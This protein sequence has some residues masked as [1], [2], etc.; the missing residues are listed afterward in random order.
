MAYVFDHRRV[1]RSGLA[2]ELVV[3]PECLQEFD[4]DAL[5]RQFAR[6][7]YA[8]SFKVQNTTFVLVTMHVTYGDDSVDRIRELRGIAR[9]MS[10]WAKRSNKW[11]HNLI[12]LGDFN[13]DR[14]GDQLWE[15]FVSTGLTVP[16]DL[17]QVRRRLFS[18][19][20]NLTARNSMIRLP[21]LRR[22]VDC[23]GCRF[24]TYDVVPLTSFRTYIE[25]KNLL[26]ANSLF[27]FGFLTITHFGPSFLSFR[28]S[29][30]PRKHYYPQLR[31]A[32]N[33]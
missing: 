3:S 21:D 12:V 28:I 22:Q 26:D 6:T 32:N 33:G 11:H 7:P 27:I 5:K 20:V 8:V 9:W 15:A 23:R 24:H 25:T 1:Q 17:H 14:R 29:K 10:D 4:E 16:E 18:K 31:S 30:F 2:C 13:I 19:K